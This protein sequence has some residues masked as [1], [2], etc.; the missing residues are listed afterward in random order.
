MTKKKTR[1]K[2]KS[3]GVLNAGFPAELYK[4]TPCKIG[5]KYIR[6]QVDGTV[7]PC[8]VSNMPL[9]SIH[10]KSFQDIWFS[11]SYNTFRAKTAV[12]HEEHFHITDPNWAFCQ[13]CSHTGINIKF[14]A[15]LKKR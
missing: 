4:K 13:Q 10:A 14:A 1:S 15:D 3:L 8:C 12:I 9:G 6:L 7:L 2:A 5:Y 11:D